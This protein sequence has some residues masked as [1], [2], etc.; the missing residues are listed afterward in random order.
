M[1]IPWKERERQVARILGGKRLF[2]AG[3]IGDVETD[4]CRADVKSREVY[5]INEARKDL[6]K[7]S[8]S[9]TS[10]KLPIVVHYA[11]G[12]GRSKEPVVLMRLKDFAEWYGKQTVSNNKD[13][14]TEQ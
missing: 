3:A 1:T 9:G 6:E 13:T 11:P 5:S 14:P 4:W 7:L 12:R 2:F 8:E 10:A